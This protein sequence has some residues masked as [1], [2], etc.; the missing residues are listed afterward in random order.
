MI[1]AAYLVLQLQYGSLSGT[2]SHGSY[3]AGQGESG[4]VHF[5]V[6]IGG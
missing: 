3:L 2:T 5:R 1:A 6:R 4:C